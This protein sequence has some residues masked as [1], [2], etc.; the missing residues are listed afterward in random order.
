MFRRAR[1]VAVS[2]T[3]RHAFVATGFDRQRLAIACDGVPAQWTDPPAPAAGGPRLLDR[4]H[5]VRAPS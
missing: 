4:G 5:A 3:A 2:P 1:V